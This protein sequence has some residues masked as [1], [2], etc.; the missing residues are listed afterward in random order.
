MKKRKHATG[1]DNVKKREAQVH[2]QRRTSRVSKRK[3]PRTMLVTT[4]Q[5]EIDT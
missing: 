1:A 5:A 4:Q 3:L 2:E